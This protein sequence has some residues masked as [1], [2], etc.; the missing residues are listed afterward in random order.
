M[1][2]EGD[3][4]NIYKEYF[5]KIIQYLSKIA[6]PNDAEDMAQDV[7]DR[8]W[9]NLGGFKGNS[10]LST[11]SNIARK[12]ANYNSPNVPI[13]PSFIPSTTQRLVR[14]LKIIESAPKEDNNANRRNKNQRN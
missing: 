12:I 7:F 13:Q 2:T 1:V 9:R 3:F 11:L 6:G 8:I 10:K 14:I 5:P 4:S